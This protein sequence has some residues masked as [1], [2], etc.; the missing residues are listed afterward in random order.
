MQTI[1][2]TLVAAGL[3]P[4][5]LSGCIL[6]RTTEHRIKLNENG[7]GEALLRL[8]DIRSDEQTDSLVHRDFDQ[9]MK[10]Y[11]KYGIDE[12]EKSGRK[13]TSKQFVVH[14][15]T[16]ILEISYTFPHPESVEG[17]HIAK[18]GFTMGVNAS[19]E[20]LRTNG[21]MQNPKPGFQ[22]ILWEPGARRLMYVIREKT[23]PPSVSLTNLYLRMRH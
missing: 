9:M 16:L 19:R 11:D 7:S 15:D 2:R 5:V 20:V 1:M 18:D 8:I 14:G 13:I 3:L 22:Q 10:T 21:T 17:L 6:V 12:F 23:M 4:V